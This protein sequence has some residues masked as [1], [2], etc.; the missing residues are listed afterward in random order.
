M[1]AGGIPFC[2]QPRGDGHDGF[3]LNRMVNQTAYRPGR[4]A[5]RDH[6]D[7]STPQSSSESGRRGGYR[8]L[9]PT[10]RG[11]PHQPPPVL[12]LHP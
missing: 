12:A 1:G 8:A 9:S 7:T 10:R 5:E 4:G 3:Q 11:P 2:A 6:G